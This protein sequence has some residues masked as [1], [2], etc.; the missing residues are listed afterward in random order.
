MIDQILEQAP[1]IQ[2]VVL[3]LRSQLSRWNRRHERV[4]VDL[5]VR[6]MKR[7]AHFDAAILERHHVLHV[8]DSSE[9]DVAVAPHL[10]NQLEMLERQAAE[11]LRRVLCEHDDLADPPA[12]A[13]SSTLKTGGSPADDG[14]VG[15]RFSKTATS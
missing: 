3:E 7:D 15:N 6:M 12:P 8:R 1:T 14:S 5:S 9:L 4:R 11:T 2:G 10:D 13:S